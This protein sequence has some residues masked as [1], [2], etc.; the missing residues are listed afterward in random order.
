[1]TCPLEHVTAASFQGLVRDRQEARDEVE[2]LTARNAE[3]ERAVMEAR[4]AA[5]EEAAKLVEADDAH[6][7]EWCPWLTDQ[8]ALVAKIRALKTVGG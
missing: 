4:G 1:M 6:D 2:I 5:L 7:A 8:R 3:L